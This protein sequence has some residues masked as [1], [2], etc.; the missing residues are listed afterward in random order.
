MFRTLSGLR[1]PDL[2]IRPADFS[3]Q[4]DHLLDE[5]IKGG[6]EDLWQ[7]THPFPPMRMKAM[8]LFWD[9]DCAALPAGRATAQVPLHTVDEEVKRILSTIDP[10]AREHHDADPLL[11]DLLLWGGLIMAHA[12]GAPRRATLDELV[13]AAPAAVHTDPGDPEA[14][15]ARFRACLERRHRRLKPLEIHRL[16]TGFLRVAHAKGE[17]TAAESDAFRALGAL[18]GVEAHACDVVRARFLDDAGKARDG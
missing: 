3:E 16:L 5:V 15:Q 18:L 10:L 13:R 2:R 1:A 12:D 14:R 17:I 9:S 7:A 6:E 8:S 4:W 11:E